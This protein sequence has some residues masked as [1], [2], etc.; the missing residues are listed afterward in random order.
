MRI[1]ITF[2]ILCCAFVSL[3]VAQEQTFVAAKTSPVAQSRF[4]FPHNWIRGYTDFQVAPSHNE[5]DLGRCA[6]PQP[7]SAGGTNSS[8]TAYARYLF[9]GYL[10]IQ[11][12]GRT[13]AR[14]IFLFLE[15]KMSF[16]KNIPQLSYLAS[17][18]PIAYERSMGIGFQLPRGFEF[19]LTQ[20]Q[21]DYL[22]RYSNLLGPADL[23][24]NGP[25]GLYTTVG[26]RWS[27]GGYS[28]AGSIN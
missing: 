10:E 26:V 13:F 6:F 8:C 14:H 12:I 23:R 4:F 15:P 21:V 5:P 24:T 11:P 7:L 28:Q 17:M 27:F 1:L 25:Y 3:T 2:V 16:G 20:H 18:E 22:G 19:R 9:S